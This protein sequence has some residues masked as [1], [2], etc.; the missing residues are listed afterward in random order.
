MDIPISVVIPAYNADRFISQLLD[1][2]YN[3]EEVNYTDYEVVVVNDGSTDGTQNIVEEYMT[4]HP[5]MCIKLVNQENR[6]VSAAR[7]AGIR[8]AQGRFV[9]FVDADD[10]IVP[11]AM[12][13]LVPI[14]REQKVDL[15]KIGKC[16]CNVLQED[17]TI[18]QYSTSP[19]AEAFKI[20]DAYKLLSRDTPFGSNSFIWLKT[21]LLSNGLGFPE[22]M[23]WNE[24]FV[25][26]SQA[27]VKAD[28]A[29]VNFT[30]HLYLYR[31][32]ELS[33]CRGKMSYEKMD[34]FLSNRIVLLSYLK[35]VDMSNFSQ[36]KRNF[37]LDRFYFFREDTIMYLIFKRIPFS[38]TMYYL[39]KLCRMGLYPIGLDIAGKNYKCF[40]NNRYIV[41]LI[42]FLLR[43]KFIYKFMRFMHNI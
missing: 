33:T 20:T 35:K 18:I 31:N 11:E 30:L 13:Y 14:I 4:A 43:N 15:I 40:F 3:Q 39:E 5:E 16:I 17:G 12:K 10:E 29:Y 19:S 27:L 9:W 34:K 37:F 26:L 28:K 32:L 7:N 8:N 36:D 21:F 25:F 1:S 24:D 41:V 42:S 38:L 2:L 23:I 22:D 6:G